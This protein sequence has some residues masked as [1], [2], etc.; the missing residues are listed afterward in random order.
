MAFLP[1]IN[2]VER[3]G[4]KR[5]KTTLNE[6][7]GGGCGFSE[8]RERTL[9]TDL[10]ARDLDPAVAARLIARYGVKEL[11]VGQTV[12]DQGGHPLTERSSYLKGEIAG[13]ITN[14]R[15]GRHC[16]ETDLNAI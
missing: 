10:T 2:P 9:L 15:V 1:S 5:R 14:E 12:L 11:E 3:I 16:H 4:T 6:P 13:I 7:I 8:V